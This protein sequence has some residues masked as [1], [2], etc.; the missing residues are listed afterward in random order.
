MDYRAEARSPD[1]TN[2][3]G[4]RNSRPGQGLVDPLDLKIENQKLSDRDFQRLR[5]FVKEK[6]GI[7][8]SDVKRTMLQARLQKR[9]RELHLD[10]FSDYCQYLFSPDGMENEI[11]KF[12]DTVTTNKTD[13][14]REPHHFDFLVNT[15]I[16]FLRENGLMHGNSL[17]VWSAACSTGMEPYTLAMVLS[18]HESINQGFSWSILGT[19]ISSNVLEKAVQAIYKEDDIEP[20]SMELRKKYLLRSSNRASQLVK[21]VPELRSRVEFKELNFIDDNYD[22][23]QRFEII[24]CRNAIIYFDRATTLKILKRI[25]HHLIPGGFLF[26]GHSESLNGFP[27]PFD[28]VGTTV[29]QKRL[30]K[31]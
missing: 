30:V 3:K 29:Y 21:I 31:P 7:S 28:T 5:T 24:F 14:F 17:N 22:I 20:V 26:L 25:T 4:L 11:V 6:T 9:L 19:D 12:I 16:P 18:G 27:I 1:I 23:P 8:L 2:Q 15:A 10:S 13:F